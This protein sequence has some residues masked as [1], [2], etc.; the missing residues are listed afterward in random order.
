MVSC[1]VLV[2]VT[3]KEILEVTLKRYSEMIDHAG[4]YEIDKLPAEEPLQFYH[5]LVSE[6]CHPSQGG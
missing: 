2:V 5:G 1:F 4:I 6:I 3:S